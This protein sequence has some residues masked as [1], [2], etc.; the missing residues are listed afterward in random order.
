[1]ICFKIQM[2]PNIWVI[3]EINPQPEC[4]CSPF[5]V[6]PSNQ[7][8]TSTSTYKRLL[9]EPREST[10][11]WNLT[12]NHHQPSHQH[13]LR[14]VPVLDSLWPL[15]LNWD[16]GG[17]KRMESSG[18]QKS[19]KSW[20][21][22]SRRDLFGEWKRDPFKGLLVTSNVWGWKGHFESPGWHTILLVV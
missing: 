11:Y 17:W 1:M 7:F 10:P 16:L 14:S 6:L 15:R 9:A 21:F 3:Y 5:W 4:F 12:P 22:F 18:L 20:W 13:G 8:F 2:T 19:P